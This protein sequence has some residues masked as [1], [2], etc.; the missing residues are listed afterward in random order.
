MAQVY[1]ASNLSVVAIFGSL[2]F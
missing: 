2:Q 1:E